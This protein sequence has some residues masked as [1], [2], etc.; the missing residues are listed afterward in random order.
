[1]TQKYIYFLRPIGMDGPIK[2]GCSVTPAQRLRSVEIWS[3]LK[4]EIIASAPGIMRHEN[5]LHH[6]FAA[7]RLHGEWFTPSPALL[8]IINHVQATGELPE[9]G[10]PNNPKEWK[11]FHETRKGNL[12]RRNNAARLD[13][14]RLTKRIHTAE[15]RVFGF[16]DR[17]SYRPD[18]IVRIIADYQGFG[19][20]APTKEQLSIIEAY[21]ARLAE[22][23]SADRSFAAWKQW[24]DFRQS[25]Q[26]A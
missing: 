22:M 26:A 11:A 7:N 13:K 12:P 3:P 19:S 9:L 18:E 21:I 15:R 20:P 10:I 4:L 2:I 23:P 17:A 6:K 14:Y 8:G 16:A 25:G 24:S 5:F 1:M